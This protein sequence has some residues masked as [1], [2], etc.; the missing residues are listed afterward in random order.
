SNGDNVLRVM[1]VAGRLPNDRESLRY[2]LVRSIQAAEKPL[3]RKSGASLSISLAS[4]IK[5][6]YRPEHLKPTVDK[7][8]ALLQAKWT[9]KQLVI[10][11]PT[12][13][14]QTFSRVKLDGQDLD[15]NHYPEMVPPY[16]Q[17]S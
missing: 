17:I 9:N 2:L 7:S 8:Y 13:Y 12:P 14:Y 11:N 3:E 4:K 16:G 5:V 10:T 6:F 15:F 1:R